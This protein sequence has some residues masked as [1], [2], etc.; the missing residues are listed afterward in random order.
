MLESSSAAAGL[1]LCRARTVHCVVLDLDMPESGF[2]VL[3]ELVPDRQRPQVAVIVLTHLPHPNLFDMAKHNGVRLA[4]SS[5]VRRYK[6]WSIP[7]NKNS[8]WLEPIVRL[9][10][11][12]KYRLL[13]FALHGLLLGD[14][15][16]RMNMRLL[17][18]LLIAG[19][20]VGPACAATKQ[21]RTVE[22]LGF[23]KDLY[24]QMVE[25]DEHAG[26]VAALL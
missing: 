6:S 5:R 14:L 10:E 9:A 2:H 7:F 1:E 13:F 18:V 8:L 21:A 17:S 12:Q 11:I 16:D 25:G 23:L 19:I 20:L 3:L 4:C 22:R 24:P 15:S 26:R